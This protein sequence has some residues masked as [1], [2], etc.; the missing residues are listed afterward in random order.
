MCSS[1]RKLLVLLLAHLAVLVLSSYVEK[2]TTEDLVAISRKVEA[3]LVGYPVNSEERCRWFSVSGALSTFV[4]PKQDKFG[5]DMVTAA[6]HGGLLHPVMVQTS[7]FSSDSLGNELSNYFES[8]LCANATRIHFASAMFTA[9]PQRA[10]HLPFLNALP[11][12]VVHPNLDVAHALKVKTSQCPCPSMCHEWD[13]G[14]MHKNMAS[15]V[16]PL[17]RA[18]MDAYWMSNEK[19][20]L[21]L[22]EGAEIRTAASQQEHTKLPFLPDVAIHYRC[23]DNVVTHY[24]FSPFRIFRRKIPLDAKYIYV[25]ADSPNRNKKPHN[26]ARCHA[27]FVALEGY[28]KA[29]FPH[30][31]VVILRGQDVFD[32]L[33]RLTYANTTICSVSTFCLWPAIASSNKAYF[34]VSKLIAK[35][36]TQFDY[37]PAFTWLT[38]PDERSFLGRDAVSM[39]PP[40]L[41]KW[42]TSP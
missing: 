7:C 4:D 28:L 10:G 31:T 42:L 21:K 17:F 20:T 29:H 1:V 24:G 32:D 38:A 25:M 35:E 6:D 12:Q 11:K 39:A 26:V 5:V 40:D 30:A 19:K 34:P 36:H 2:T 22:V 14:L 23:G 8:L 9:S 15:F 37:G 41:V 13:Y 18:A 3:K 33:A 16:R 27:I